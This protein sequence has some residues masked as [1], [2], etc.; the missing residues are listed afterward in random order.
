[1]DSLDSEALCCV[2]F[3]I[4]GNNINEDGDDDHDHNNNN[5]NNNVIRQNSRDKE[6][7]SF[8]L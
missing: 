8:Q 1:V 3:L 6:G 5:N 7:N 4:F 2:I